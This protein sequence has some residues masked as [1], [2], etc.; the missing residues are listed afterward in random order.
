MIDFTCQACGTAIRAQDHHVGRRVVCPN[1]RQGATVPQAV[2][3]V[4]QSLAQAAASVG[5]TPPP[6]LTAPA[7]EA[8][9]YGAAMA[10][11]AVAIAAGGLFAIYG[12]VT[13]L[14]AFA[15]Q[16]SSDPADKIAGA[17]AEQISYVRLGGGLLVLVAGGIMA[18]LREIAILL[19]HSRM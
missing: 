8:T 11:A 17:V 19:Q 1:C 15:D 4:P 2:A 18:M 14:L 10:V 16:G 13:L 6:S 7:K 12:A 3:L 5:H 9:R